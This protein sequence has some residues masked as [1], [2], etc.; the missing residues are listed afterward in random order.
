MGPRPHRALGVGT[1][2]DLCECILNLIAKQKKNFKKI[3][4]QKEKEVILLE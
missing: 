2:E 3:K 4:E 1:T